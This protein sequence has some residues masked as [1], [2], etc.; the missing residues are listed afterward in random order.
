[1]IP[2]GYDPESFIS[3]QFSENSLSSKS[4]F[5]FIH[6]GNLSCGRQYP[7]M[8]FLETIRKIYPDIPDVRVTLVGGYNK[9]ILEQKFTDLVQ[10][11]VLVLQSPVSQKTAFKMVK[12]H[13]Y[14]LQFNAREFPY[15]VSTKIYE[16]GMLNI[17]TVSFNYGGEIHDLILDHDLGYSIHAEDDDIA[18]F[19]LQLYKQSEKSFAFKVESFA[20]DKL[21][22][23]YSEVIQNI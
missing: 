22:G 12:Q 23:Q 3:D 2:N 8:K 6:V 14:A 5:S 17:P 10:S 21:A 9:R 11:K 7:L 13:T 18:F 15:L 19:L 1:V 16:Y 4:P 20:Y